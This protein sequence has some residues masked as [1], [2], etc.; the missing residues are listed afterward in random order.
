M[1]YTFA[2]KEQMKAG[3]IT[4]MVSSL[5]YGGIAWVITRFIDGG[6]KEFF[7]TL[8][9]LVT[10]RATYGFLE[11]IIGIIVWRIYGRRRM[12]RNFITIMREAR[13]PKRVYCTDDIVNYLI[14][15]IRPQRYDYRAGEVTPE[16]QKVAAE[17]NGLLDT[18]RDQHGMMAEMRTW[19]AMKR[20]MEIHSPSEDSPQ[21]VSAY[22]LHWLASAV[23]ESDL[24]A[25]PCSSVDLAREILTARPFETLAD[26][27]ALLRNHGLD[28]D[29]AVRFLNGASKAS[30]AWN[31]SRV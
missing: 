24:E 7:W 12:V 9:I 25:L 14:R 29:Q 6:R 11:F 8:G 21:F 1:G 19:D 23:K 2:E 20:A 4:T 31:L 17:L 30:D 28:R 26:V 18:V 5:F 3:L 27:Y 15:I 10:I 22:V 13:L 16:I